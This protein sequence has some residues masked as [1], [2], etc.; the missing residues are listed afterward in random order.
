MLETLKSRCRKKEPY[1]WVRRLLVLE[2]CTPSP[3]IVRDIRLS[4]GLNI[5]WAEEP[6]EEDVLTP[7]AGH[8]AGKTTFC[9]FLRY[10][11]G[12]TTYANQKNAKLIR[13]AFENGYVAAE[14]YVDGKLWAVRRP[15]GSGRLSYIAQDMTVEQLLEKGGVSVTQEKYI[16]QLRMTA[17]LDKFATGGIARSGEP[18]QWEH[19]LAW[20]TRDQE[21]RFQSVYD[22]RSPRSDSNTPSFR[23]PRSGALF[24]MRAALGLFNPDEIIGEEKLTTLHQERD[25]LEKDVQTKRQEPEY[26]ANYQT[27]QLRQALKVEFPKDLS[28]DTLPLNSGDLTP[29][30]LKRANDAIRQL[31]AQHIALEK[32]A[33]DIQQTIDE[34]NGEL[35]NIRKSLA[36]FLV[37]QDQNESDNDQTEKGFSTENQQRRKISEN[38]DAEC[39]MALIFIRDC[40][41][42]KELHEKLNKNAARNAHELEQTEARIAER[43]QRLTAKIQSLN[44][45]IVRLDAEIKTLGKQRI[46]NQNKLVL[47]TQCQEHLEQLRTALTKWV[48]EPISPD[49]FRELHCA[50]QALADKQVEIAEQEKYL[51]DLLKGHRDNRELLEDLFS[52]C[53]RSVIR[54][55]EYDGKVNFENRELDFHLIHGTAMSGEAVET[56]SILLADVSALLFNCISKDANL[57]GF[58]LHDSPREADLGL[59]LYRAFISFIATLEATFGGADNSPFQYILTTTSP[60][61]RELCEPPTRKDHFSAMNEH[62]LFLRRNISTVT[63]PETAQDTFAQL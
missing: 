36:T 50:E 26:R 28:I 42:V 48:S 13:N 20:M 63:M 62:D 45:E 58:L 32:Q 21:A 10:I 11:L 30:L 8:S 27:A 56:L 5:I 15:I 34:R 19:I 55:P 54:A 7:I 33:E 47:T 9:R 53:V 17:L 44:T 18:I 57:P 40:E 29:D 46:S 52:M 16:E 37:I 22:W 12:E 3:V 31:G 60:P 14:I 43:R 51:A 35:Q 2:R 59:R 24:V 23:Y 49:D 25:K 39:D 41:Y 1:I 6:D 38:Q 4:R 61:P